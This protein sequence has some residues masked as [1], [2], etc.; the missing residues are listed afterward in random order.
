MPIAEDLSDF[1]EVVLYAMDDPEVRFFSDSEPD[2][3]RIKPNSR[4][5]F[6]MS[7]LFSNH[8]QKKLKKHAVMVNIGMGSSD[9]SV[10]SGV[11]IKIPYYMPNVEE[12]GEW[13]MREAGQPQAVFEY[14][15]D[16][17][18]PYLCEVYPLD[19]ATSITEWGIDGNLNIGLYSYSKNPKVRA[20]LGS[21]PH[22]SD[23]RDGIL[24]TLG[25][26]V[27]VF[28]DPDTRNTA[29]GIRDKCRAAKVTRWTEGAESFI[30]DI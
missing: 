20:L 13:A 7:A 6:G 30:P 16:F 12:N 23:Y 24:L 17:F 15:I 3:M 26:N 25:D 14:L 27:D 9:G 11:R 19:F 18:D 1:D 10:G 4:S 5:V 28:R 8:P 22:V 29:I 21:D 2:T